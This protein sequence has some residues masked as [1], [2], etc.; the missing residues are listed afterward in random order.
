MVKEATK[1]KESNIS[2]SSY[3]L[4]LLS[5]I[6]A[7]LAK[8]VNEISKYFKKQQPVNQEPKSYVQISARQTNP[9]SIAREM[10]KIKKVFPKLQNKKI[11]IVQKIINS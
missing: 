4:T 7:K 5:P 3:V 1:A 2:H 8:K 11:K 9:T 10:L 6:P